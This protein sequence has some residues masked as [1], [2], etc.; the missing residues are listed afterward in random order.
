MLARPLLLLTLALAG[1]G[2]LPQ[3]FFGNPGP[4]AIRLAQPP[5][6]RLAIPSPA[7]SL[8]PDEGANAW[9]AAAAAALLEEEIPA[10][11]T[12]PRRGDWILRMTAELRGA[13]V[14]PTYTLQNSLGEPQGTTQGA[15]VPTPAWASGDPAVLK[16]AAK[17]A[18]PAIAALLT[19]IEAARLQSDPNSLQ[20]RPARVY[21]AGVTGAPGDG[22]R[23]LPAQI[24]TKLTSLGIV[25]QDTPANADYKLR[26]EVQTA[27]GAKGTTRIELQW[28]VNDPNGAERGRIL[29][30]N[31][32][33][34]GSLDRYWGDVAVAAATEAAAGVKEVLFNASGPRLDPKTRP[35]PPK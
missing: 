8:L 33:P 10:T 13:S 14:H 24:R 12:D 26:G 1:C 28:I 32:V 7:Q 9:A 22:D 17:Q 18:A 27:P 3:P 6:S 20:N 2:N 5:P 29:Q 34:P 16:A 4:N 11:H 25:V 21:L 35:D 31:E 23:S 19:Q 15:P 30:L